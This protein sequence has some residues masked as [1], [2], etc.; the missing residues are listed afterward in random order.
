MPPPLAQGCLVELLQLR[1]NIPRRWLGFPR[2]DSIRCFEDERLHPV[3]SLEMDQVALSQRLRSARGGL[4]VPPGFGMSSR[5]HET[6]P[7]RVVQNE[8]LPET[9]GRRPKLFAALEASFHVFEV[10][11]LCLE[12]RHVAVERSERWPLVHL[13]ADRLRFTKS[14]EGLD[15]TVALT[16]NDPKVVEDDRLVKPL[17]DR[18]LQLKRQVVPCR[19]VSSE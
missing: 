14:A 9:Q 4:K 11:E 8:A 16:V 3:N 2:H 6:E 17:G 15:M 13:Q 5:E 1:G 7:S 10:A 19:V 18:E 12:D